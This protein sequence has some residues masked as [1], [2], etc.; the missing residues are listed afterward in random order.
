[1]MHSRSSRTS[2]GGRMGGGG[3]AHPSPVKSLSSKENTTDGPNL[4]HS[5]EGLQR[6][7]KGLLEDLKEAVMAKHFLALLPQK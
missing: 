6:K 5:V 1:M 3:G 7:T 4:N 2:G